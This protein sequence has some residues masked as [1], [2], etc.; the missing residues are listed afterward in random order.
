[1]GSPQGFQGG[2][3]R[4]PKFFLGR[5]RGFRKEVSLG[6]REGFRRVSERLRKGPK[7][8]S[9]ASTR[10]LKVALP[11]FIGFPQGFRRASKGNVRK[12]I[13]DFEEGSENP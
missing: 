3:E 11:L 1:M 13:R 9:R 7:G 12:P 8:F 2:S 4:L 10:F 6:L 5:P